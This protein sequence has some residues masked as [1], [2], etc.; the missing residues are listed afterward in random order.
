MRPAIDGLEAAMR[1][2]LE[3]DNPGFKVDRRT[4]ELVPIQSPQSE[5]TTARKSER[6]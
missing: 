5:S 3:K 2:L 6:A 1:R 4:G